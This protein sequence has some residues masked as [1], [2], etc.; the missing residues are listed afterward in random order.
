MRPFDYVFVVATMKNYKSH[1]KT[2][3]SHPIC[4]WF[5]RMV[6]FLVICFKDWACAAAPDEI[7]WYVALLY[8]AVG[9]ACAAA[10]EG[11]AWY[12]AIRCIGRGSLGWVCA[13]AFDE[14]PWYVAWRHSVGWSQ[15]PTISR[16]DSVLLYNGRAKHCYATVFQPSHHFQSLAKRGLDT[17]NSGMRKQFNCPSKHSRTFASSQFASSCIQC[18]LQDHTPCL[19]YS[20][21]CRLL[22]EDLKDSSS[23]SSSSSSSDDHQH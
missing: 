2:R 9:W 22:V 10:P 3:M 12:F 16:T 18:L 23:S 14:N 6:C 19:Q 13:A 21:H 8:I 4:S 11:I 20:P 15:Q 7:A 1:L 17:G 5:G